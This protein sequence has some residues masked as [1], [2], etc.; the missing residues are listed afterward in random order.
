M[1]RRK[2]TN[3]YSQQ[4]LF[5]SPLTNGKGVI[6]HIPEASYKK[7]IDH[8]HRMHGHGMAQEVH[9]HTMRGDVMPLL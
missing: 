7:I 3:E 9:E 1:P 8:V 6:A 2:L 5:P 4:P